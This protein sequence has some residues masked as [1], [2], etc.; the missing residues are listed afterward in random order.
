VLPLL[1]G[2]A[3]R[4]M[5]FYQLHD[6]VYEAVI[7]FGRVTDTYDRAGTVLSSAAI[8]DVSLENV[9]RILSR[10]TGE[11]RQIPPMYSAVRVGGERLYRAARR[12]EVLRRPDRAIQIY[13]LDLVD[14]KKDRWTVRVHCSSGTYV[15]TLAHDMGQ[16]LGCGAYLEALRR[17]CSGPFDLARVVAVENLEKGWRIGYYC[18]EELLTEYPRVDLGKAEAQRICHG[19]PVPTESAESGYH[20]LFHH[21]KILALAEVKGNVLQP[22]VVFPA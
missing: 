5:R 20:R 12:G 3:T 13:S 7:R 9:R 21:G 19:N 22:L 14:W 6:K 11:I 15:R 16:D 18:L 10:F 17:L 8:P 2:K 1:L 4:L